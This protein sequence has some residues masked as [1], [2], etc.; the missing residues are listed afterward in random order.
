MPASK[1]R[2]LPKPELSDHPV[3]VGLRSEAAILGHLIRRGYAVLVPFGVNQ[4][5]DLVLDLG[6]RFV[7]AQCKTGRLRNGVVIFSTQSVRASMS[8]VFTRHYDG[9]AEVFLVYCRELDS[10]Y[11]IP[12]DGAPRTAMSLRI[13]GTRNGQSDGVN[14]AADYELPA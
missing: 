8:G 4:R 9:E 1:L 12:V 14:W 13:D 6:D 2:S 7:R 10:C 11:A 3:D 5:Y